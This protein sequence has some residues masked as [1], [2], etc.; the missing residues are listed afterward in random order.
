MSAGAGNQGY[1]YSYD[2]NTQLPL[3]TGLIQAAD[4]QGLRVW[5]SVFQVLSTQGANE[6]FPIPYLPSTLQ[7]LSNSSGTGPTG[8][9]AGM[10]TWAT[11]GLSVVNP[12]T[13]QKSSAA[14]QAWDANAYSV[15]G[16]RQGAFI[17]FQTAQT[18]GTCGVGFSENPSLATGYSNLQFGYLCGSA[19]D[20]SV[21]QNGVVMSTIGG[22]YI[23]TTQL[24][25]QY[26]GR[27]V[28]YYKNT[29][30]VYSTLRSQGNPLYL[31]VAI[32]DPGTTVQNIHFAPMGGIGPSGTTGVTGATGAAGPTGA[33]GRTGATG[34]QGATGRT[35]ATGSIGRTGPTGATGVTGA[36]GIIGK[37]GSI[38]PTGATGPSANTSGYIL[39]S[40]TN[41]TPA[42]G[43]F[44]VDA[45]DLTVIS[46]IKINSIDAVGNIK[47][48]F[49]SRIGAGSIIHLV[50]LANYDEHIYSVDA[51]DNHFTYWTFIITYL[52]GS[53]VIPIINTNYLIS[54]DTIGAKGDTGTTGAIGPTGNTGP[55]GV[56]GSAT[57]TGATGT[58]GWTGWTG[59]T[60]PTGTTGATGPTG[61]TGWTG[62]TGPTGATGVTGNTGSTGPTG[63]TGSTGPTGPLYLGGAL[64]TAS[65]Y[66]SANVATATGTNAMVY[67]S[68]NAGASYGA[69]SAT[70]NTGSGILTNATTNT[71]TYLITGTVYSLLSAATGTETIEIWKNGAPTLCIVPLVTF[72]PFTATAEF[73]CTVFLS[74]GDTLNAVY[75]DVVGT[76][77]AIV[78]GVLGVAPQITNISFTQLDYVLGP[79]GPTGQRGQTGSTGS[80][81][82]TGSTGSTGATG[83]TGPSGATGPIGI[84]GSATSTGATGNTGPTGHD[85]TAANTGATGTTGDTGPTGFTGPLGTG[86]TG[87]TGATGRTGSTGPT[88]ATGNTGPTGIPGSATLTG[89]TGPTG[90]TGPLGT[91]PTGATGITGATGPLGTGPTGATGAT[92]PTGC[93]GHT[94][95]FGPPGVTGATG[96]TGNT[97]NTGNTGPTGSLTGPTGATG[98]TGATGPTGFTG[99][100]GATGPTGFT[101]PTGATGNTGPTGFTGPTGPTG[102]TGP[103][104]T[105]TNTG[106][107]GVGGPTGSTGP[108]TYYIFDGGDPS[109]SFTDGPAFNCGG[110][111]ITGTTGPSGAY[112]GAN[113]ILQLRHAAAASWSIVNP[114]LAQGEMG[115]ETDTEQF[116]IGN[117][118]TAWNSLGYGGLLGP[119]GNTGP[120]GMTGP[121]PSVVNSLTIN[122]SLYVQET[123]E[124]VG[125]KTG[126]TGVVVHDWLSGGIYY[127][128]GL[129]SN[130]TCNIT[131][132]P[133]TASRSY[134]VALIF[135][136]SATPFYASVLQV[137]GVTQTM[138]WPNAFVSPV[139]ALR[140][141]IQTF[142]LYY[143]GS[144][145]IVLSQ[146]ASFG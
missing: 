143:T 105:A 47:S 80:T 71:L 142:T 119:T 32:R 107:T 124:L 27:T 52:T 130:F 74:A 64:H 139:T 30:P 129:V 137:N 16:F 84:P 37:T 131:N 56:P 78:G 1:N 118:S 51:I 117:G 111:G 39:A 135:A 94:G 96:P 19:A 9:A 144:A 90:F 28:I 128:T 8:G 4:G 75:N 23:S 113:I 68:Y 87:R 54:F 82:R 13:V 126:A 102:F 42:N 88:G 38:G 26:D 134:V 93:T 89:A 57:D 60:G 7:S 24:G 121:A 41:A 12:A 17:T 44:S 114:V 140:T 50:N 125:T 22:G 62:N 55:T 116:K 106:A 136:Q 49:F 127:H 132:L 3:S 91:G 59:N 99:P 112:N 141:E 138:K 6:H 53:I 98:A 97:G 34:P 77:A 31:D 25:I 43:D 33:T 40:I 95:L 65:Y 81:G 122:G 145:W 58:T 69:I 48:G 66:F 76:S 2:S 73:S 83:P 120:T 63:K 46:T 104:G 61:A 103:I 115:Y 15:E 79:T 35:G 133:T 36:T 5:E 18:N 20:L 123:Q 92:G 100:T 109:T 11:S 86:P 110:A 72:T 14:I 146:L 67:D 101:G 10:F 85:G 70:Y 108:I 45:S 21:V 29:A